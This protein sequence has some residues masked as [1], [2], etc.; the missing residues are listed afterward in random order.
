[1]SR[2]LVIRDA[3]GA[4]VN[5]VV[6]DGQPGWGPPPGHSARRDDRVN[7]EIGDTWDGTRYVKPADTPP[8]RVGRV[9]RLLEILESKLI[10]SS[11]DIE[12]LGTR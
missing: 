6:W 4:V 5:A 1:M 3:D 2:Y 7:G 9:E 10:L 11:S 8:P 12:D